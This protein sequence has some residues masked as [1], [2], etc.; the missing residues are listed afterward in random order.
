M[1]A[2][3]FTVFILL[4][5][6]FVGQSLLFFLFFLFSRKLDKKF[7]G[8][9][10][11]D[12]LN[13]LA[14][15]IKKSEEVERSLGKSLK[16]IERDRAILRTTLHKIGFV[17]FNPFKEMGGSYSF[18][19]ALL[20]ADHNGFLITSL[21][22]KEGVRTYAKEVKEGVSEQVITQEEERALHQAMKK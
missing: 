13:L 6:L 18:S 2:I 15:S 11:K 16:D 3:Q 19:I 4:A 5:I 9:N 10:G 12:I 14:D 20:D 7:N 1:T 21:Y 22:S 17:R 8:A